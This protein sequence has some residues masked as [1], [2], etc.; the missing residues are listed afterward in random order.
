MSRRSLVG[1]TR[2]DMQAVEYLGN[3]MYRCKC[4]RCGREQILSSSHLKNTTRCQVC[5]RKFK[6]DIRGKRFGSLTV[7]D[8]DKD[9]KWLCRC[10]CGN[11]VSVKSNN[12]KSG[13]TRSCR[14]CHKGFFDNPYLVE[15]TLVTDLTQGV[16]KNN[17]SGTTGVYYNKRKRKWYA[18]MMFQG[19][20]YF[21]GYYSNKKDAIAARKEAEEKLHGP[22]LEWYA[23]HYPKQW[24][25]KKKKANR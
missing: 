13:N 15:G 5:G 2:G 19:Q 4:I 9:G 7:I 8:Y 3:K 12:L 10:D 16:R 22:F 25:A 23:E 21:F 18:A 20:N 6:K 11:T 17:T 14:K 24:E 1:V